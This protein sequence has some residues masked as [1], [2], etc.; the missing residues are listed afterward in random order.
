MRP[1]LKAWFCPISDMPAWQ[2]YLRCA[3]IV[4]QLAAGYC[5]ASE[6]SPFFYQRF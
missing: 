6:A 3:W 1:G 4:L 5:L 2:F